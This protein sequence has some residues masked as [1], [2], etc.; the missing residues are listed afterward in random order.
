MPYDIELSQ[1]KRQY[2]ALLRIMPSDTVLYDIIPY[3]A[4]ILL[5]NPAA[6]PSGG[7]VYSIIRYDTV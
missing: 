3:M 7:I 2:T 1:R 5:R 6:V 4:F